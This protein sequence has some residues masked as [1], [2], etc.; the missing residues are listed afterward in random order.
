MDGGWALN[1]RLALKFGV[2]WRYS[3]DPV[4][5]FKRSDTTTTASIVRRWRSATAAP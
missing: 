4:P 5:G 3:H 2:L 1:K